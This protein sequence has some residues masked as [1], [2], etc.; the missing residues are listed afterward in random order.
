MKNIFLLTLIACA[1]S[2]HAQ[3]T[4]NEVQTKWVIEAN[5]DMERALSNPDMSDSERLKIVQKAGRT[6]KRYGQPHTWPNGKT[7]LEQF[8]DNQFEQCKNEI[9]EMNAWALEL[10]SKSLDQKMKIINSIQIEV[11]EEQVQLLVPGSTPVQLTGDAI[12]TVFGINIVEG[13]NAGKV[14]NAQDLTN[15]FKELAKSK[16]LVKHINILVENHKESLELIDADRDLLHKKMILWKKAYINARKSTFTEKGLEGA[17]L[18][19]GNNNLSN[20]PLVGTWTYSDGSTGKTS[21]TF[22]A[23]KTAIQ[24]L[25]GVTYTGWK[26]ES[27]GNVITMIGGNGKRN[28]WEYRIDNDQLFLTVEYNGE[29]IEGIPLSKQ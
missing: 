29:K 25:N 27:N 6:Q 4:L 1:I 21:Y 9:V 16:E 8:I 3:K 18:F 12:N 22:N 20:N 17:K 5:E 2:V 24:V 14:Q 26:W 7:P 23:D 10:E 11:V 28:T 15:K 13:V 19:K